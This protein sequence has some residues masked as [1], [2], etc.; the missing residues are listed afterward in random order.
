MYV[1]L[2]DCPFCQFPNSSLKMSSSQ[3]FGE[4]AFATYFL[5][6]SLFNVSEKTPLMLALHGHIQGNED[7]DRCEIIHHLLNCGASIDKFVSIH[8]FCNKF[9]RVVT[10]FAIWV[11]IAPQQPDKANK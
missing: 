10:Q 1:N 11:R 6:L 2:I 7:R 8:F 4:I 5:L 3:C 9:L